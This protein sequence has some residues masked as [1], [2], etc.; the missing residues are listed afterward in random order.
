MNTTVGKNFTI[1]TIPVLLS[2]AILFAGTGSSFGSPLSIP[3][4]SNDTIL[5]QKQV[6]SKKHRI[7]LFQ[8]DDQSALF[9]SVRGLE[10]KIYQLFI[11]DLTGKLVT[12]ANIKSKQTTVIDNIEKGNYLFEVFSDD[13]R[14][15]NGQVTIK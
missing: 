11:F 15:E 10:G 8:N 14:I 13:V 1:R 12:Q 3:T 7:K 2:I 5:V 6:T 4:Y 9:F